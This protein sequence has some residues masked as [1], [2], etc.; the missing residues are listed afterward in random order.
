MVA[1]VP[2]ASLVTS[3]HTDDISCFVIRLIR[4]W[5]QT[6]HVLTERVDFSSNLRNAVVIVDG[7]CR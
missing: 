6:A 3:L 5:L 1:S 7:H 4:R 2:A